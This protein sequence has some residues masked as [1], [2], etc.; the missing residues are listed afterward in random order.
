M[1][2]CNKDKVHVANN[3]GLCNGDVTSRSF[4]FYIYG[5]WFPDHVLSYISFCETN[6][7]LTV[8]PVM[9][10]VQVTKY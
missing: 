5:V 1:K 10:S 3:A 7:K 2:R 8:L 6:N 4:C 9:S